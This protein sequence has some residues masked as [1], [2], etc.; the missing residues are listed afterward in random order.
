MIINPL[1]TEDFDK[2]IIYSTYY[3]NEETFL[4]KFLI[5]LKPPASELLENLEEMFPRH[6]MASDA[7]MRYESSITIITD[8]LSP[9]QLIA[10]YRHLYHNCFYE[11]KLI[12]YVLYRLLCISFVSASYNLIY[13][14]FT[15]ISLS[16]FPKKTC[17][18]YLSI[19]ETIM[20]KKGRL[21]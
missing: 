13:Y 4:Q 2:T 1:K 21:F 10:I 7:I 5:I 6:Y 20:T 12:V 3:Y 8:K 15:N 14:L 16:P 11:S 18:L 17:I 9:F 19:L